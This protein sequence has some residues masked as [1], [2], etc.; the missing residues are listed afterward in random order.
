MLSSLGG[1][2]NQIDLDD[3][4]LEVRQGRPGDLLH[5]P[6]SREYF[7]ERCAYFNKSSRHDFL[8]IHGPYAFAY[9]PENEKNKTAPIV[10]ALAGRGGRRRHA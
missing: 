4:R 8:L 5:M 7:N 10:L 9:K 1:R 6:M 3:C 2:I